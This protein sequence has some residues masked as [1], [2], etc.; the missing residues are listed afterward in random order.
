ML[1]HVKLP[2]IYCTKTLMTII[3]V[4]NKSPS[5]RRRQRVWS[6]KEVSYRHIRVFGCLAYVHIVGDQRGKLDSKSRPCLF[7]GYGDDEFS[8]QLWDLVEKK[9]IESHD[10]VVMEEKKI[11]DWEIENKFPTTELNRVNAQPNRVEVD[12]I[13]IESEPLGRVNTQQNREPTEEQ[14]ELAERG[15]EFCWHKRPTPSTLYPSECELVNKLGL[16]I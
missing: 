9:L 5:T 10:I 15:I 14:G 11:V 12:W 4:I 1:A 6:S 8:Y 2:K 16:S 7:L 13:E 3:Y